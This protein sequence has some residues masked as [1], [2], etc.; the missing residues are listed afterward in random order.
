MNGSLTE[1]TE[2]WL[3]T[4]DFENYLESLDGE[5]GEAAEDLEA[6]DDSESAEWNPFRKRKPRRSN[7]Y[8][9]QQQ[10]RK[11]QNKMRNMQRQGPPATMARK[12][13]MAQAGLEKVDLENKVQT[14]V[15][16]RELNRQKTRIGLDEHAIATSVI[17]REFE[18]HLSDVFQDNPAVETLFRLAPT[19]LLGFG[20]GAQ[21]VSGFLTQPA[22]YSV[23]GA[24]VIQLI[25]KNRQQGQIIRIFPETPPATVAAGSKIRLSPVAFGKNGQPSS[26]QPPITLTSATPAIASILPTGEIQGEAAGTA[27]ITATAP[28]AQTG[29]ATVIVT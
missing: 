18:K 21:G 10:W 29:T 9:L 3:A 13:Q 24:I 23:I 6:Y 2:S 14:D 27:V 15:F 22:V 28:G 26:P 8:A 11:N 1:L 19:A 4:D 20:R 5:S 25:A 7:K 16:S 12:V 17:Q